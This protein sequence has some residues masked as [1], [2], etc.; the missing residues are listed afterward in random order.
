LN[1]YYKFITWGRGLLVNRPIHLVCSRCT[2]LKCHI[3]RFWLVFYKL[4]L[5][6]KI[7]SI[8]EPV[9]IVPLEIQHWDRIPILRLDPNIEIG[10]QYW[11]WIPILRY[12]FKFTQHQLEHHMTLRVTPQIITQNTTQQCG[13]LHAFSGFNIIRSQYWDWISILR[14]DSNINIEIG[15][16]YSD[17]ISRGT[18]WTVSTI[19]A[20]RRQN[21]LCHINNMY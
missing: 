21:S 3:I 8:V 4:T 15:S 18:I 1:Y 11:D 7:L 2:V 17:R 5:S 12:S 9:Q 14:F 6:K 13:T 20:Q 19:I 10:S 16:Q